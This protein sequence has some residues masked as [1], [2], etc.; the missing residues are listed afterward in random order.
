MGVI[1]QTFEEFADKD[2]VK[3]VRENIQNRLDECAQNLSKEQTSNA[4]KMISI[5][6]KLDDLQL[7]I[8]ALEAKRELSETDSE[9]QEL[10][11]QR[12]K[13]LQPWNIL[14]VISLAWCGLSALISESDVNLG[15]QGEQLSTPVAISVATGLI[16]IMF[17]IPIVGI[18]ISLIKVSRLSTKRLD[19]LRKQRIPLQKQLLSIEKYQS[20]INEFGDTGIEEYKNL[21][22]TVVQ[23]IEDITH[24]DKNGKELSKSLLSISVPESILRQGKAG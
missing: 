10:E 8:N 18:V 11:T 14:M 3:N 15:I 22:N 17:G 13:S 20:L 24:K 9:W 7:L 23:Y 6:P 5:I 1:P 2:R 21:K 19:E 4:Q 16:C 12:K